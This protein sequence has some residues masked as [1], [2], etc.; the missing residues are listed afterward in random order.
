MNETDYL[1]SII[2]PLIDHPDELILTS[3]DD[4]RG[5][6]VEITVAQK[7]VPRIIG[8]EGATVGS[9]RILAHT[10]GFKN[11]KDISLKINGSTSG[12]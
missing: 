3:R 9:I 2:S 7:D 5:T 6:F 8:K 11:N 4:D 12:N 10:F 1:K